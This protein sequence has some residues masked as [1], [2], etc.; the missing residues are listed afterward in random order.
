MT[1][2]NNFKT[3]RS[4][5]KSHYI[6]IKSVMESNNFLVLSKLNS[7]KKN[8][9]LAFALIASIITLKAQE[10]PIN[11]GFSF[12]F[13]LC[14]F[15]RD[16]GL[17]LN[18]TSQYFAKEKIAVRLKGNLMYNENVQNSITIW[19]P[20]TNLSFGL[21]GASGKLGEYIRLYG[22]GGVIGLF[23]SNE[24]SSKQFEFGGYGL[25]GFEFFM[26]NSNNYFIEIGG[27]GVGATQDKIA[28]QPIYS[29]GLLISTGFRLQLKEPN[30]KQSTTTN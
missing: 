25:F 4:I 2:K 11:S 16:F 22:E 6:F 17:G 19:T 7:M 13:Q 29:N 9:S 3:C 26:N 14:Q 28:L 23:P 27:V 5:L 12:G 21:I 20:Y 15:Q 30:I 18:L 1:L 8:L 24:F 10:K